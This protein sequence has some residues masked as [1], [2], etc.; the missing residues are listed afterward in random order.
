L[1][2]PLLFDPGEKWQYG[3][4]IDWAGRAIEVVSGMPLE[5]YFRQHIFKPLG[6]SDTDYLMSATQ[7]S[8]VVTVHQR[9]PD[10]SLQ[11]TAANDPPWREFWSGGGGLYSTARDYL[12]FLQMILHQGRFNGV[13]LLRP[14]TVALMNQNQIGDITAGVAKTAMPERS[15][16]IDLFPGIPCRWGLAYMITTQPGPN[17]RSAGSLTWGG[18]FNTY[19]WLDPQKRIAGVYLA[20]IL[21]FAD[22]AALRAYGD[23][24]KAVYGPQR[25]A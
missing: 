12:V 10:G 13:Q 18:I 1:R 2:Q 15:N 3:I 19:Y 24:E 7:Q 20:Q 17:G 5:V 14:Q 23:F 8:R 21:P 11:P 6:M 4:N 22:A 16:D 25:T 9:R